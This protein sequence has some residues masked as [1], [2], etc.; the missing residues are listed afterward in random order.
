MGSQVSTSTGPRLT[1]L[2]VSTLIHS[3]LARFR[4]GWT[5]RGTLLPGNVKTDFVGVGVLVGGRGGPRGGRGPREARGHGPRR[6]ACHGGPPVSLLT[7]A[8]LCC[9]IPI[10]EVPLCTVSPFPFQALPFFSPHGRF[11]PGNWPDVFFFCTTQF[12]KGIFLGVIFFPIS[13][14][15]DILLSSSLQFVHR[16]AFRM[17]NCVPSAVG[18]SMMF[19]NFSI[20]FLAIT[21]D[22]AG[23]A[24]SD[25]RHTK[26]II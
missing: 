7:T 12:L 6:G 2:A 22:G 1:T 18:E 23:Y 24:E 4:A 25:S 8:P 19:P 3:G 14:L 9:L 5:P 16:C 20:F 15:L 13:Q 11:I 21:E 26:N 17:D 10:V